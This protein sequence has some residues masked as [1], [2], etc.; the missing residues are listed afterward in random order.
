MQWSGQMVRVN[1][2]LSSRARVYSRAGASRAASRG[3][4]VTPTWRCRIYVNGAGSLPLESRQKP[5]WAMYCL[6]WLSSVTTTDES[7]S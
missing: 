3:H 2:P 6:L 4:Q 1:L 7:T 5:P